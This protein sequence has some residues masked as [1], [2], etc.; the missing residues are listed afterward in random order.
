MIA[1]IIIILVWKVI[2]NIVDTYD[3]KH[4]VDVAVDD[5]VELDAA[6]DDASSDDYVDID[7]DDFDFV[8]N[9]I[10]CA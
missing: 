5:V 2:I 6:A 10:C 4:E 1:I 7:S 3:N 9:N 8:C